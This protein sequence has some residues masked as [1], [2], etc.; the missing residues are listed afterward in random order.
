MLFFSV[1]ASV[2]SSTEARKSKTVIVMEKEKIYLSLNQFDKKV[3][4]LNF[5][6]PVSCD[7]ALKF[8]HI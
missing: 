5:F 4:I 8:P 2:M 3:R 1:Q 6:S 7:L